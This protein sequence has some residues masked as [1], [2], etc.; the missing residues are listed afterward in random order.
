MAVVKLLEMKYLVTPRACLTQD[1][2]DA[3]REFDS[4]LADVSLHPFKKSRL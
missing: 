3:I 4:E 2:V 1:N